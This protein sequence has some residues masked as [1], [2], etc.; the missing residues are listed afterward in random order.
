MDRR[1]LDAWQEQPPD[2]DFASRVVGL[3]VAD[4]PRDVRRPWWRVVAGVS[5]AAAALALWV[6]T[7]FAAPDHGSMAA[8]ERTEAALVD[9]VAVLEAGAAITWRGRE[10]EQRTGDVFYRVDEGEPFLVHTPA[11]VVTVKGTCFRVRVRPAQASETGDD[12]LKKRDAAAATAGA[13]LAALTVVTVYEGSVQLSHAG[14]EV[15]VGAG[16]SAAADESGV[17]KL[18]G[19]GLARAEAAL[20]KRAA[21]AEARGDELA[22][23]VADLR[24]KVGRL[25]KQK[26]ELEEQLGDAKARLE[27]A[28]AG[29]PSGLEH[30]F[31]LSEDDWAALAE[32]GTVKYRVPCMLPAPW[33]PSQKAVDGL[34]LSPDDVDTINEAYAR[35]NDRVWSSLRELCVDA[36][37]N[38]AVV[39]ILG[40]DSCVHVITDVASKDDPAAAGEAQRLVAEMR[41]GKAP[42]P[43]P[44]QDVHPTVAVFLTMTGE[45]DRFEADLAEAYGPEEAHRLAFADEMCMSHSTFT[46]RKPGK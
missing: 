11:G 29:D 8:A 1:D 38:E 21:D 18:D 16:E 4:N 43:G 14:Q 40:A 2:A 20:A 13:A 22:Q 45:L 19:D 46:G 37:G 30:D 34:G 15:A 23:G 7:H 17:D 35:S 31:D 24:R 26:S 6:V 10:V 41:A 28:S 25:E 5:L 27:K 3:A 33:R 12:M 39:D 36:I 9:A 44:G 32:E 42:L